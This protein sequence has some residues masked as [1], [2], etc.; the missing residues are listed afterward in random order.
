MDTGAFD[1]AA[2]ACGIEDSVRCAN[3][4]SEEKRHSVV[5]H[6]KMRMWSG[7]NYAGIGNQMGV[8]EGCRDRWQDVTGSDLFEL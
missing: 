6:E 4:M 7:C 3:T 2:C 8:G 1:D 5:E